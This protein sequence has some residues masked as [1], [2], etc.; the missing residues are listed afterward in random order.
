MTTKNKAPEDTHAKPDSPMPADRIRRQLQRI[1]A[2]PTFQA[3]E[4]QKAFLTFVVKK[5]L[6]GK[7]GEIKGYTVATQVF[8]RRGD[9]DQATDPIVSIQANKLRRA[10]EHY[11][12]TSGNKDAIRI[13][14]PK[15]SYVPTFSEQVSTPLSTAH[16]ASKHDLARFE[17]AWPTVVVRPFQNLTGKPDLDFMAIGMATELA[18][19]ITRFQ[20]IRV[21]IHRPESRRQRAEDMGARFA[22]DGSIREDAT[23]IKVTIQLIDLATHTQIWVDTNESEF[24]ADRVIA[25][26]E[27]VAR[28]I[29]VKICGEYGVI[30]R[31]MSI[32][33]K[34]IPPSDLKTYE[35]ILCYYAFNASFSKVTFFK[36]LQ[37]LEQAIVKEPEKGIAWSMLA[38]LYATNHSLEL[39]DA[40]T[41]LDKA[42]AFAEKG[43][44]LDPANQRARVIMSYVLLLKNDLPYGLAEATRAISLNPNSLIMMAEL[45]YLLTLLGDWKR[46]PALIRKAILNNPYYDVT[47]HNALWLD[48]MH[49]RDYENA[50]AETLKSRTPLLFW[51]PLIKAVSLSLLGRLN[52][53]RKAVNDLLKLKPD[54]STRGRILIKH[55]IKFDDIIGQMVE[56][57]KKVG[58]N[59]VK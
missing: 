4:A 21:L 55:Y 56:V 10:L 13:K 37:A 3:T 9:F 2:S 54:F 57:L 11:Y 42:E 35:A 48:W 58:L 34:N 45:G 23:G 27:D 15:G 38:R 5:T 52:K 47:V 18:T 17:S 50:Y 7:S 51:D 31:Q 30:A 59:I 39:F 43:V 1:L 24:R 29:A 25:F 22:I 33:S 53:G 28:V 26:Q 32:E 36:A 6:S 44:E 14:I 12:L 16:R 41:P 8:G 20:D 19:E 40:D 46:G 49:R